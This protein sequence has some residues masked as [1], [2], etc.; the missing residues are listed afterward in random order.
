MT[1][2][3][4]RIIVTA[5]GELAV[6]AEGVKLDEEFADESGFEDDHSTS[7]A[8]LIRHNPKPKE[9]IDYKAYRPNIVGEHWILSET[10]LCMISTTSIYSAAH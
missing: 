6:E 3:A 8:T 9:Q 4:T 10:D 5:I 2:Q 1:N 7:M